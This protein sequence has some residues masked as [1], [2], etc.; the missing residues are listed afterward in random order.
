MRMEHRV[1]GSRR[2]NNAHSEC[3]IEQS[4]EEE[5]SDTIKYKALAERCRSE[6]YEH[7]ARVLEDISHE[8]QTHHDLLRSM[9]R[10]MTH[11]SE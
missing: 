5:Q 1:Y 4:I 8:E 9:T 2:I 3:I 7:E 6:G 10:S 11:D